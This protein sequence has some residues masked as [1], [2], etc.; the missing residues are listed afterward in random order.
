MR[1]RIFSTLL[2]GVALVLMATLVLKDVPESTSWFTLDTIFHILGGMFAF[3]CGL[4]V[5]DNK[6]HVFFLAL[7]IGLGWELAEYTSSVFGPNYWPSIYPYYHGGGTVDTL[8]DLVADIFGAALFIL[9]YYR[10]D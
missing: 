5:F 4:L 6:W 10:H 3:W 7:I 9:L 8:H 2:I 1:S